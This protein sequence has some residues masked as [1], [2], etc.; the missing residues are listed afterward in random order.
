MKTRALFLDI[1]GV[2]NN[3][4]TRNLCPDSPHTGIDPALVSI[5]NELIMK[6]SFEANIIIILSSTWRVMYGREKTLTYM[7][8]QGYTGPDFLDETPDLVYS[9]S[10]IYRGFE[11]SQWMELY[12]DQYDIES[13]V[14]IDDSSDMVHLM[15]RLVGINYVTGI[16]GENVSQILDLLRIPFS[17]QDVI[18]IRKKLT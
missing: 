1:D 17:R 10:I 13:F 8:T 5:L 4:K 7:R 9:Q 11:I 14:I 16:T 12:G 3:V 15:K 18:D 6:A 2:L